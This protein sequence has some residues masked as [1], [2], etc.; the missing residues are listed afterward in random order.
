MRLPL[1]TRGAADGAATS[2]ERESR[3][4]S[5]T[6]PGPLPRTPGRRL[7]VIAVL[8]IVTIALGAAYL[9]LFSAPATGPLAASGTVEADEVLI[10]PELSARLVAIPA[11]E[12]HSVQAG[13]VLARLD[14]SLLELQLEQ[15]D[16]VSY[17]QLLIQ[18]DRYTL[19]APLTGLITRV[20]A[21][22]GEVVGPGSTVAAVADLHHLTLTLYVTERD[23]A[24]VS[25]GQHVAITADPFP[26]RL[27]GGRVT[28]I[29]SSAEFTPRNVQTQHDRLNLVFG[30]K[31]QVD[32]PD[33]ALKPGMPV[34][35][36]FSAE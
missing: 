21:R 30:V 3:Q 22:V 8:A 14:D 34:D 28:S 29:N 27:F 20:P 33:L 31:V 16:P 26:D 9:A 2:T 24:H 23:L 17:R 4:T 18:V 35:A 13:E 36:T 19:R 12:G 32:N 10:G 6:S 11:Q 1:V 25:V 7:I 15:A 5:D